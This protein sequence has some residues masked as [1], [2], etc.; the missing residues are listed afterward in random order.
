M[1]PTLLK[2]AQALACLLV[3]QK[4][5]AIV[6]TYG[7]Y[8]PPNSRS[9]FLL[10]RGGYF[11]GPYQW[12][13]YAHILSGP[14]ALIAGLV[15]MSDALRRRYPAWHRNL[16]RAEVACVLLLVAPSGLWMA[17]YAA[18]GAVAA[19][20]FATLAVA[21]AFCAAAGWRAA[22]QRRFDRHRRW[23]QRCFV[24]L[25]SAVVLRVMGGLA[26][27][28]GVEG[29]YPYAAWLCWLLPL[30]ALELLRLNQRPALLRQSS[31]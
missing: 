10:G 25:S 12:A 15:L 24:L 1:T 22:V 19:A 31:A 18:T 16:G 26:E 29:T 7:D 11:F 17:W 2:I 3:C 21:T 20:G 14:F 23:M 27:V 9:D 30:L 4:T 28:L 8:F 5:A 6:L 13:F